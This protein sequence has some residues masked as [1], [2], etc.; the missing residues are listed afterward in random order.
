MRPLPLAKCI[1]GNSEPDSSP[2]VDVVGGHRLGSG[3]VDV[4]AA[5][6][7]NHRAL[8]AQSSPLAK[9][10]VLFFV[11]AADTAQVPDDPAVLK[12]LVLQLRS[13]LRARDLRDGSGNLDRGLGGIFA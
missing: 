7:I 8:R 10:R 6:W 1:F 3:D 13:E 11:M 4:G 5:A 9:R 2:D 12:A